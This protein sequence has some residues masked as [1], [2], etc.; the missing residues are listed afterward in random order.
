MRI[1]IHI[2]FRYQR[3]FIAYLT[4]N[5][6]AANKTVMEVLAAEILQWLTY[7]CCFGKQCRCRQDAALIAKRFDGWHSGALSCKCDAKAGW[8]F[9]MTIWN[10]GRGW[11]D[12][13][14]QQSVEHWESEMQRCISVDVNWMCVQHAEEK[15][16]MLLMLLNVRWDHYKVKQ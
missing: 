10:S 11:H 15:L 8:L 16:S 9:T 12:W 14:A 4:G 6:W 7:L 1:W 5:I 13:F 3:L 2:A